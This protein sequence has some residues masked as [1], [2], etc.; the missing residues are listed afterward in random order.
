MEAGMFSKIIES[1]LF[2]LFF[3]VAMFFIVIGI[4]FLLPSGW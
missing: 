3:F 1:E 2:W 4:A